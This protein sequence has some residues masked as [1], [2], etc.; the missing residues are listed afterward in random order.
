MGYDKIG[1]MNGDEGEGALLVGA[2]TRYVGDGCALA[3]EGKNGL[4]SLVEEIEHRGARIDGVSGELWVLREEPG[5]KATVA[6]PEE[7]SVATVFQVREEVSAGL[8]EEG[9]KGDVF[10]PA[11]GAGNPV[12]IGGAYASVFFHVVALEMR[13]VEEWQDSQ[14]GE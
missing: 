11:I 13:A 8:L 1:W 3:W 2:E 5:G 4:R 14:W 10:E 7:E 6:I 12:E 9:A